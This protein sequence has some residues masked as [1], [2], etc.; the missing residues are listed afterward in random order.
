M[1]SFCLDL[2]LDHGD[3]FFTIRMHH[4]GQ[5]QHGNDRVYVGGR[6]NHLDLCH[7]DE[8]SL[9]ELENM[10]KVTG[11]GYC[12]IVRF[13]LR[14]RNGWK[15]LDDDED[16][17]ALGSWV[18]KHKVL[19]V[20]VEHTTGDVLDQSQAE[21]NCIPTT[22]QFDG[23]NNVGGSVKASNIEL[24]TDSSQYDE[25]SDNSTSDDEY[26]CNSEYDLDGVQ[27]HDTMVDEDAGLKNE[28][29]KEE[30]VDNCTRRNK[31]EMG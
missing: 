4:G 30:V 19:H 20:Y 21:S 10:L 24:D 16:V 29:E 9:I 7:I 8:L 13:H 28:R 6:V 5:F 11:M 17:L 25:H 3:G 23:G 14:I 1:L 12:R 22:Q 2:A 27:L 18:N 31:K 26:F 15:G